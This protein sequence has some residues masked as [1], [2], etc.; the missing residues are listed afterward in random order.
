MIN[1]RTGAASR[2][3]HRIKEREEQEEEVGGIPKIEAISPMSEQ[4]VCD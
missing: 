4:E 1:I 2:G 3:S